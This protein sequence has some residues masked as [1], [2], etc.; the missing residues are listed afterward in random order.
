MIGDAPAHLRQLL[1]DAERALSAADYATCLQL[2]EQVL[3]QDRINLPA[4]LFR[5]V[6]ASQTGQLERAISDLG[7]VI[8]RQPDNTQAAFFLGQALRRRHQYEAALALLQPLRELAGLGGP[9]RLE[10][11]LCLDRLGRVDEAREAY[12]AILA[13]DPRQADAA[14]NLAA[15]LEKE[16]RLEEASAWVERALI[17]APRSPSAH[18][19]RA[20]ILRKGGQHEQALEQLERLLAG[21]LKHQTQTLALNEMGRCLDALG[22]YAEAFDCFHDANEVQ[23]ANDPE[24]EPDD[25]ASY[26]VELAVFLRQ[27][28]RDHPPGDWS[29]TPPD[30]REPP[31]F[32]VGF[33]MANSEAFEHALAMHP[34][35]QLLRDRELLLE[36]RRKWISMERFDRLHRMSAEEIVDTRRLYRTA[37]AAAV[38]N[39]DAEV[40]IDHLPLN[41][42]WLPLI[43]RLFPEARIIRW[44]RDPRD[45]CL[46]CY[47]GNFQLVGAMPYFLDLERTTRYYD[48]IMA[49]AED[50]LASLPI[51][52]HTL[53]YESLADDPAAQADAVLDFLG[54]APEAD[55]TMVC[56]SLDL[57]DHAAGT[58][59][60]LHYADELQ[61]WQGRLAP[62]VKAF[63]YA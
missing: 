13:D 5:G 36:V 62:W 1:T 51:R 22:R 6:A 30:D 14:A 16:G 35:V 20:R 58:G 63:D 15:L 8:E 44:V 41:S 19:T 61:P 3:N 32:L 50:A 18:L 56:Q 53:R 37:R 33:P 39:P 4:H 46:D 23:R 10:S 57:E 34:K 17:Q 26:G 28:L 54:L 7:Y 38:N 12:Q 25:F 59:R 47:F 2:A 55:V 11:A 43:H 49:L 40:V 9:A 45:T 42:M 60:W 29:Q 48:V 21:R 52:C 31:V 24:A 27:W